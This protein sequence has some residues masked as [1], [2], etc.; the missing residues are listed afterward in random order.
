MLEL[1]GELNIADFEEVIFRKT[2]ISL[3]EKTLN[4]IQSSFDFLKEFSE[5]KIIYGV[6]TGFGPMAQ[7]KVKDQ[8]RIELQYN[9][10]R[11]HS[12]GMG[13]PIDPQFVR[14]AMLAR[15][16][17]LSLGKSGVHPS[18]IELMLALLNRNIVPLIPEHGGVRS[19]ERR[20]G[21]ECRYRWAL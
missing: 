21:K 6:N 2:S 17:T 18:V 15:L 11:S 8:E 13:N 12:S 10:I 19:E 16:N 1:Q 4:K 7:Y 20:V 3:R 5:N 14:A 9:L